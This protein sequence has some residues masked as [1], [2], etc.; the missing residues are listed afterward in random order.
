MEQFVSQDKLTLFVQTIKQNVVLPADAVEWAKQFLTSECHWDS[1]AMASLTSDAGKKIL[2]ALEEAIRVE[3]DDYAK[4]VSK[5]TAE[6]EQKGKQ[7]FLPLRSAITGRVF[8]PELAKIFLLMGKD[9]L[10]K[11]AQKAKEVAFS[12]VNA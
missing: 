3:G 5:I 12:G 9:A 6:T 1:D 2:E 4:V 8:G 10:L 7:L 11:R